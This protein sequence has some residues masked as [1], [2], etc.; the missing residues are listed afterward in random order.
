MQELAR[1][2]PYSITLYILGFLL[3]VTL[4]PHPLFQVGYLLISW[5]YCMEFQEGTLSKRIKGNL[6]IIALATITNPIVQ[7]RGVLIIFH[8][9]TMPVTLE[10]I[11]YGMSFGCMLASLLNIGFVYSKMI[12]TDQIFYMI[13]RVSPNAAILCSLSMQQLSRMK[14]QYEDVCYVRGLLQEHLTWRKRVMEQVSIVSSVLTWLLETGIDTSISM[15][16]RGYGNRKRSC[17]HRYRYQKRDGVLGLIVLFIIILYG[18]G[19]SGITFYW[20]PAIYQTYEL[21]PVACCIVAV[22]CYAMIPMGLHRK[23]SAIWDTIIS[24]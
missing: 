5:M 19:L 14:R 20:Y 13:N 4:S 17:Y 2:H 21:F 15:K 8:I 7:H 12:H 16:S 23:E 9:G 11:G 1:Y 3:L 22:L 24:E 10:A 18:Y 6:A